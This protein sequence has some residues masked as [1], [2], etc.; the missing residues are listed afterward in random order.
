MLAF[1]VEAAIGFFAVRPVSLLIL[2]VVTEVVFFVNIF[3][4][5]PNPQEVSSV[6]KYQLAL[7]VKVA[8]IEMAFN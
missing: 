1:Y 4:A 7:P 6:R 3:A 2:Q 5:F 8:F